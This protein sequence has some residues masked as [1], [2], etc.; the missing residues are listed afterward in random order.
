MTDPHDLDDLASAHLDGVT[1]PEEAARVA[2]DPALLAR[3]AEL[4]AVRA[5]VGEVPAVDPVRRDVAIAAAL[6]AFDEDRAGDHAVTPVTPLTPGRR[7]SPTTI[8]VLSAAAVVAILALLV[9]LLGGIDAGDDDDASFEATGDAIEG[10]SRASTD[11]VEVAEE[12]GS[13]TTVLSTAAPDADL[14]TY[15]DLEALADAVTAGQVDN[16]AFVPQND[17]LDGAAQLCTPAPAAS[18]QT[19]TAV[20][21]GEA[22][23][24]WIGVTPEGRRLLTVLRADGCEVLDEREL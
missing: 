22:V 2:A 12:S 3:V 19:G 11:D 4:R 9:P 24:V 21:A 8:R 18:T 14:G 23:V 17:Q 15:E 6:A 16:Q 7:L 13:P 1:S 20:V 10:D 5:A